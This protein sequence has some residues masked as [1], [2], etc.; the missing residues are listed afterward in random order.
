LF[1]TFFVGGISIGGHLGGAI[2]GAVCAIVMLAPGHKPMQAWATYAAPVAVGI[3]CI[4]LSVITV[5]AA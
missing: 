4:V 1:L 2:A 5:N 3:I